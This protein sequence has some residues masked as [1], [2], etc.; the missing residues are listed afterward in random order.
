[1]EVF[2]NRTLF[3]GFEHGIID[4]IRQLPSDSYYL[5]SAGR[6]IELDAIKPNDIFQLNF[7]LLGGKGGFGSVLRSF[8]ISKSSNQLMCRDLNGR[9]VKF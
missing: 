7:R 8:R 3:S 6:F 2:N 9:L 5:L 4:K 1:M